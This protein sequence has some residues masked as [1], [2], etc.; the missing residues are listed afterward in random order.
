[1]ILIPNLSDAV[2]SLFNE[3]LG[4]LNISKDILNTIF[5]KIVDGSLYEEGSELNT[6]N[7]TIK[8][9]HSKLSSYVSNQSIKKE[10]EK[11]EECNIIDKEAEIAY[12]C[13]LYCV[14]IKK[15][16][17]VN[18]RSSSENLST[19]QNKA[20]FD[21]MGLLEEYE[22][23]VGKLE[24]DN[25]SVLGIKKNSFFIRSLFKSSS[26]F[27]DNPEIKK[28]RVPFVKQQ[29]ER[30]NREHQKML[31]EQRKRE[32]DERELQ[33]RKNAYARKK[34]L[35]SQDKNRIIITINEESK[36]VNENEIRDLKNEEETEKQSSN[37]DK[38]NETIVDDQNND[39]ENSQTDT[40]TDDTDESL[41]Q[42]EHKTGQKDSS[43][44]KKKKK[45]NQDNENNKN[46]QK[47]KE[48]SFTPRE[49]SNSYQ[50]LSPDLKKEILDYH[51]ISVSI[52]NQVRQL[53]IDNSNQEK[54]KK[55]YLDTIEALRLEISETKASNERQ[56]NQMFSFN[57]KLINSIIY[58]KQKRIELKNLGIALRRS[59]HPS[60]DDD[61]YD[62][63]MVNPEQRCKI[64][65]EARRQNLLLRNQT[66]DNK[67]KTP[68]RNN[69]TKKDSLERYVLQVIDET[70]SSNGQLKKPK[71]TKGKNTDDVLKQSRNHKKRS[72]SE[73]KRRKSKNKLV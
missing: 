7:V 26:Q 42:K 51:K 22:S 40:I 27:D 3:G 69:E 38:S 56:L 52:K 46:S 55:N 1:M 60:F 67:V 18:Y 33:E 37:I 21:L 68:K 73:Y 62:Y 10:E 12:N 23:I 47:A 49:R 48:E 34:S 57:S 11:S 19:H 31:I 5:L 66:I 53:A 24:L 41:K 6:L 44:K 25:L 16:S 58:R 65:L 14:N 35:I 45:K 17:I 54:E 4:E 70:E 15:S 32:E 39:T 30:W 9:A 71:Q 59:L 36:P 2:N 63:S 28:D 72:V 13:I 8:N 43:R 61:M 50:T 64:A 20:L 29:S